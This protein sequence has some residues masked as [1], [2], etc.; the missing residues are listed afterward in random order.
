MDAWSLNAPD[1][2]RRTGVGITTIKSILSVKTAA[3]LDTL[4]KLANG[5]GIRSIDLISPQFNVLNRP[6]TQDR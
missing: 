6:G 4:D 1:V 2:H 5:L 3:D